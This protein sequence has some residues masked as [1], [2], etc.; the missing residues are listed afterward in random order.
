MLVVDDGAVVLAFV[1]DENVVVAVVDGLPVL[2]DDS[3]LTL[4]RSVGVDEFGPERVVAG[5]GSLTSLLFP[6]ALVSVLRFV[7][8]FP[9]EFRTF[10]DDAG[11]ESGV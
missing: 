2:L 10:V 6:L 5:D 3:T 9:P 11:V 4:V 1:V 7:M 8:E